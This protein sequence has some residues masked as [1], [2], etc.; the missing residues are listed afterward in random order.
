MIA[1]AARSRDRPPALYS[2]PPTCPSA[3]GR[4]FRC[5]HKH[6]RLAQRTGPV[7]TREQ[8]RHATARTGPRVLGTVHR[9]RPAACHACCTVAK[10]APPAEVWDLTPAGVRCSPADTSNSSS[11]TALRFESAACDARRKMVA[12]LTR[13]PA[14]PPAA[15]LQSKRTAPRLLPH[16]QSRSAPGTARRTS[17]RKP[18]TLVPIR[19][20]RRRRAMRR[21]EASC[22]RPQ[23]KRPR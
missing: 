14:S 2:P 19:T 15:P 5:A 10:H 8:R 12:A 22:P 16:W 1:S 23:R 6:N 21:L 9:T 17:M 4:L 11:G 3:D 13:R 7:R 20:A 18:R